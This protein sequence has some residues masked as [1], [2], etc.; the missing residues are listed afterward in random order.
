[1]SRGKT[2]P[3]PTFQYALLGLLLP[4][5][6][7]GYEL[8]KQL[9]DQQGIGLIW[10]VKL[11][12]LYAVLTQLEKKE[13]LTVSLLAGDGRPAR[14]MY[15]ITESGKMAF[16]EW[17]NTPVIHPREIHQDFMVKLY[18]YQT[19]KPEEVPAFLRAQLSH[20]RVWLKNTQNLEKNTPPQAGYRHSILQ[21]RKL[22]IK[23]MVDWLEKELKD[24]QNIQPH[25]KERNE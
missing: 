19:F 22:Q 15:Q 16:E 14:K 17:L 6:T 21:F 12:N 11:S 10:Q 1:M 5:A 2:N 8:H 25:A 9:A 20:C 18:F 24:S 13:W 3:F 23:A 4:G 7:Y